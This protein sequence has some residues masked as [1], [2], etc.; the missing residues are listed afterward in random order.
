LR[1]TAATAMEILL[2]V[3]TSATEVNLEADDLGFLANVQKAGREKPVDIEFDFS[4]G[5]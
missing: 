3:P 1:F 5:G 4:C 2:S